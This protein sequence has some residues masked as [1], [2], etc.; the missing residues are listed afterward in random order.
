MLVDTAGLLSI[1]DAVTSIDPLVEAQPAPHNTISTATTISLIMVD[2]HA[3]NTMRRANPPA[4]PFLSAGVNTKLEWIFQPYIQQTQYEPQRTI[5]CTDDSTPIWVRSS[6]LGASCAILWVCLIDCLGVRYWAGMVLGMVAMD[7]KK[8]RMGLPCGAWWWMPGLFLF[9]VLPVPEDIRHRLPQLHGGPVPCHRPE[10]GDWLA[11]FKHDG[12]HGHPC[13][14]PPGSTGFGLCE[15][16][17]C[18]HVNSSAADLFTVTADLL[19]DAGEARHGF[20]FLSGCAGQRMCCPCIP[21]SP[22]RLDNSLPGEII[23][24]SSENRSGA[25]GCVFGHV[26]G[27]RRF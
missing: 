16:D 1:R 27:D 22:G 20:T 25:F 2:I 3:H 10:L 5:S 13:G 26:W 6:I 24:Q 7:T 14:F 15:T 17:G 23:F 12:D 18:L 21:Y 4:M 11:V 9:G 19:Q 8:P